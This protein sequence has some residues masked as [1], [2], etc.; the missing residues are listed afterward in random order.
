MSKNDHTAAAED[1]SR[2][3]WWLAEW[4]LSPPTAD[5]LA[6]LPA[7]EAATPEVPEDALDRAWRA[8]ANAVPNPET[9]TPDELGA[10]F[11]RLF[12]GVQ[13][14]MGPPPPFESVWREDRLIGESTVQV[15]EAYAKSGFADIDPEAG[16]QDH[17]AV[18]LKFIAL[19]ALREAEAWQAGDQAG[20]KKRLARQRDFLDQHLA[21]WV[22]CWAGAIIEQAR[23][24][25]FAALAGLLKAGLKQA[26]AELQESSP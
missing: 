17:L 22:P 23:V 1:R 19:L 26:A 18:E 5:K 6:T 24:P 2:F 16:P 25:L 11:T 10:E 4:F 3:F 7:A 12:S 14:G 13:E 21:A 8:L 15:I 9:V 20:A